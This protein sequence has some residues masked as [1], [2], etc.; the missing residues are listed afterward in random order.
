MH[1]RKIHLSGDGTIVIDYDNQNPNNRENT[2]VMSIKTKDAPRPEFHTALQGL[3]EHLLEILELSDGY[4]KSMK[5][6]GLSLSTKADVTSVILKA[7]KTLQNTASCFNLITPKKPM[8]AGEESAGDDVM[9]KEA[10]DAINQM[11]AEA[12]MFVK[13]E[14]NQGML[15]LESDSDDE[16]EGEEEEE[17]EQE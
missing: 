6:T 11:I 15:A 5:M 16:E 2:D 9:S 10:V 14:R 17:E 12:K 3:K 8:E 13:G 1:I 7:K 4:G